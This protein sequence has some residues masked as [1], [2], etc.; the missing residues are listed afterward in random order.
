MRTHEEFR[1][2]WNA[3][4][5]W[6]A[7]TSVL[8]RKKARELAPEIVRT[9]LKAIF[10]RKYTALIKIRIKILSRGGSSWERRQSLTRA[11]ML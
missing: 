7:R 10:K 9:S 11:E 3:L 4:A 5:T 2:A 8:A 1:V 6:E